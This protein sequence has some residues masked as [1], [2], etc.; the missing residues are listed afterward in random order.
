MPSVLISLNQ[1]SLQFGS[2]SILHQVNFDLLESQKIGVIGRNGAGKSSLLKLLA[3]QIEPDAGKLIYKNNLS[4]SYLPQDFELSW[5]L[6]VFQVVAQ[7][8]LKQKRSTNSDDLLELA[9]ILD[10]PDPFKLISP[11]HQHAYQTIRQTIRDL[12]GPNPDLLISD[13][14][15]GEK[16]K[17]A[18]ACTFVGQP[19]LA[20][21]DEPTNHLDIPTI[22]QLEKII[23]GYHGTIVLVSHDRYFLDRIATHLLEIDQGQLHIHRGDYNDYLRAKTSRL[24]ILSK[25]DERRKAFLQREL[26]WVRAGVKARGTK[27]KGRLQRFENLKNQVNFVNQG[28][29]DLLL[30]PSQPLGNKILILQDVTINNQSTHSP[31]PTTLIQDLHLDFRPGMIVGLIGPN[32]SGK[33]SLIQAILNQRPI[34]KG[35]ITVGLN[36]VFNYQDQTKMQL[37][38]EA[39]PFAEIGQNKETTTFGTGTI[40][41][42]TYL[43]RFLFD[44]QRIMTPIG[45]FSGGE[46]ARLLLAKIFQQGGNFLILDEPTNDLDLETIRVLEESILNF[47]GCALIASHDRYFLNR[48]CNHILALTGQRN[49]ILS[50]GNYDD[51]LAK[52][53]EKWQSSWTESNLRITRQNHLPI[54]LKDRQNLSKKIAQTEQ[55]IAQLEAKIAKVKQAFEDP[56]SY[57]KNPGLYYQKVLEVEKLQTDLQAELER[58][59]EMNQSLTG[60]G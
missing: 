17:V 38:P 2:Q 29:V 60:A 42:R 35:R 50:T 1:V 30:P 15:G 6:T 20:I 33:T 55:N 13:L 18:L 43:N 53:T 12:A 57:V 39:T 34:S 3:K 52:H 56:N 28:R 44:N 36:T 31:N 11:L 26:N 5:N 8:W 7:S 54:K 51:F 14:S 59:A 21:L 27:N 32:G 49:W 41:T 25:T 45:Y 16:R 48:V 23:H 19:E 40:S 37:N 58:W 10:Q 4:L 47:E 22:E 24:E 9:D 46:K